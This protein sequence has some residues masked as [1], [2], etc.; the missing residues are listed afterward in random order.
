M[1][2]IVPIGDDVGEDEQELRMLSSERAEVEERRNE[3]RR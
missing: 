3:V 2:L 1:L